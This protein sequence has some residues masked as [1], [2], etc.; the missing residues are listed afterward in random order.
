M[1]FYSNSSDELRKPSQYDGIFT[2]VLIRSPLYKNSM[3][4]S[5]NS[6]II[7]MIHVLFLHV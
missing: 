1:W 6:Q 4:H 5:L 3:M 2:D 7:T